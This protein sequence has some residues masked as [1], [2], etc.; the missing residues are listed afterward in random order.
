MMYNLNKLSLTVYTLS[1]V[2]G[3]FM[4]KKDK[5]CIFMSFSVKGVFYMREK[6]LGLLK[7]LGRVVLVFLASLLGT[8]I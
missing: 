1:A 7:E 3:I 8:S 4:H 2:G 5:K 6:W